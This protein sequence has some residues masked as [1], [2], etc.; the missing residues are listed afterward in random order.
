LG[1]STSINA[2]TLTLDDIGA[3][4]FRRIR[5]HSGRESRICID[6]RMLMSFPDVLRRAAAGSV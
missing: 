2:L 5:L 3:S 4:Q 1:V 6:L